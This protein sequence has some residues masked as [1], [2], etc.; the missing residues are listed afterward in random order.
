MSHGDTAPDGSQYAVPT[1]HWKNGLPRDLNEIART[2]ADVSKHF[3][4]LMDHGPTLLLDEPYYVF[5]AEDAHEKNYS[6]KD[7]G[8]FARIILLVLAEDEQPQAQPA[9]GDTGA[10]RSQQPPAHPAA[11]STGAASSQQKSPIVKAPPACPSRTG[12]ASSQQPAP[13]KAPP[14][15]SRTGAASSQQPAPSKAPPQ[16][17]PAAGGIGAAA[18]SAQQPPQI[19]PAAG[20]I[21]A[22]AGSAH[23]Q[24]P[25]WRLSDD[26]DFPVDAWQNYTPR[27]GRREADNSARTRSSSETAP[28][29]HRAARVRVDEL[30][31]AALARAEAAARE[32]PPSQWQAVGTHWL[33]TA[34][35]LTAVSTII[36]KDEENGK[37]YNS[38]GEWC[39]NLGRL[40]KPRGSPGKQATARYW[41][42]RQWQR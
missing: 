40:R 5:N 15:P 23:F 2:Q 33:E 34:G 9:T 12:A 27:R 28:P 30:A 10:A 20:G 22:G 24:R 37:F 3:H 32:Q 41:A 42:R 4:V 38:N 16:I 18:G 36:Y 26:A 39:D 31:T 35:G 14:R 8:D 17:P 11:G 1:S 21:G 6:L 29:W 25:Q 19:P 13:S 7:F